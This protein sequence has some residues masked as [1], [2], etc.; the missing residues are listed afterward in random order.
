MT[1]DGWTAD[2]Q[3]RIAPTGS[4]RRA[5]ASDV[6]RTTAKVVRWVDGDTVDSSKGRVRLIGVDTPERRA[7][8]AAIVTATL[9]RPWAAR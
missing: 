3:P 4:Q 7:C 6:S 9:M 8:G 5:S 2:R 1:T